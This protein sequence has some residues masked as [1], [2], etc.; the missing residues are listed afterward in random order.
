[1][2]NKKLEM[3]ELNEEELDKVSGGAR[4]DTPEPPIELAEAA[5]ALEQKIREADEA[6]RLRMQRKRELEK[7]QEDELH[8][9]FF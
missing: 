6:K 7:M 2:D 1:M 5:K 8:S 3:K 9:H 4:P